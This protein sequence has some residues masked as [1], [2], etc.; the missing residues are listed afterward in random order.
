[1]TQNAAKKFVT[2][3]IRVSD[4]TSLT[5]EEGHLA[6][7]SGRRRRIRSKSRHRAAAGKRH[8]TPRRAG[9]IET[10]HSLLLA[11]LKFWE[12]ER[13]LIEERIAAMGR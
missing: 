2:A 6:M 3:S 1:M 7:G 13:D 12:I 11:S 9:H 5:S 4:E 8:K 10:T